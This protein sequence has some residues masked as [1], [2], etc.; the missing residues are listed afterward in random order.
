MVSDRIYTCGPDLELRLKTRANLLISAREK[1]R[2]EKRAANGLFLINTSIILFC[3]EV[4][5]IA[6]LQV[7]Y[8]YTW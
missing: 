8:C 5:F 6:L 2:R 4:H 1:E 7:Q 3:N